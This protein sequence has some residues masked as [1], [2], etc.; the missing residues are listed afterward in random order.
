MI[1][2]NSKSKATTEN[3]EIDY[4]IEFMETHDIGVSIN[5][6]QLLD[7]ANAQLL[8][9]RTPILINAIS[10]D[11]AKHIGH[12]P[13]IKG[14]SKAFDFPVNRK[15]GAITIKRSMAHD[16]NNKDLINT[17]N[18]VSGL[19]LYALDS[20]VKNFESGSDTSAEEFRNKVEEY[21][22]LPKSVK[23]EYIRKGKSIMI[24]E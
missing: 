15:T 4:A 2:Y 9:D 13:R 10:Q 24:I 5:S 11:S 19:A 16:M 8:V 23:K 12:G 22:N 6:K 3:E 20:I 1:Y 7:E 21:N 18:V 17:A 14:I